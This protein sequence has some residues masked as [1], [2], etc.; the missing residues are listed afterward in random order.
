MK[1]R[2]TNIS[3]TFNYVVYMLQRTDYILH[4]C[5]Q[6]VRVSD[7]EDGDGFTFG[8]KQQLRVVNYILLGFHWSRT[9][10][11]TAKILCQMHDNS[12]QFKW[13]YIHRNNIMH[14]ATASYITN[15]IYKLSLEFFKD[16]K[17]V[18]SLTIVK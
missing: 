14:A 3:A 7:E 11:S 1:L 18:K 12:T 8:V 10:K 13:E 5:G 9:S 4:R 17:W 2:F 16:Q 6:Y 15:Y